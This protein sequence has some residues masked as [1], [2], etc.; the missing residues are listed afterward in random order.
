MCGVLPWCMVGVWSRVGDRGATG[1]G[2][3]Q[4][5]RAERRARS[6]EGQSRDR[7]P[8]RH[9]W[10]QR[11]RGSAFA[12]G[13]DVGPLASRLSPARGGSRRPVLALGNGETH[14]DAFSFFSADFRYAKAETQFFFTD[15]VR[16]TAPRSA[17]THK[18][19]C[20]VKVESRARPPA[21]AQRLTRQLARATA[22]NAERQAPNAQTRTHTVTFPPDPP[23]TYASAVS[24]GRG[25]RGV[26]HL[27]ACP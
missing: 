11:Q 16:V 3:S 24:P 10:R 22:R 9:A 21:T 12:L 20:L 2:A 18:R 7:E 6:S 1:R 17:H 23:H 25:K 14:S 27:R 15:R 8:R 19:A 5:G 26:H 13:R 4:S